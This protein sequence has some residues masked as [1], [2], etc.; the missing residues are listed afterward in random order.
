M[1]SET[2]KAS[3]V[4]V[5]RWVHKISETYVAPERGT[6]LLVIQMWLNTQG[7]IGL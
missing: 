3:F 6:L 2:L 7:P 1:P 4:V 5:A